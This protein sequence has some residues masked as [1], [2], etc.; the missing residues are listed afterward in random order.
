MEERRRGTLRIKFIK[1]PT[2]NTIALL[3]Q[4]VSPERRE[5]IKGVWDAVGLVQGHL[6]DIFAAAD[7]A[8]KSA[9][10]VV[11]E[12]RGVCPQHMTMIAIFGDTASVETA[13][14][15]IIDR[16]EEEGL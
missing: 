6:A 8:E 13:L 16:I 10:V 1:S 5:R 15:A 9:N 3:A 4:R 2:P 7:I 12:I 14:R 11:E